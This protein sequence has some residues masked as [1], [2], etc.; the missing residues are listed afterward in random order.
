MT[1][2][3]DQELESSTSFDEQEADT[4]VESAPT[5]PDGV[6]AR[7]NLLAVVQD[8][9][10]PKDSDDAAAS[11]ADD[12][13]ATTEQ[14]TTAEDVDVPPTD[15]NNEFGDV[16]FNKHPRFQ[17]LVQQ[18]NEFRT[19]HEEYQKIQTFLQQNG[20]SAD[21]AAEMLEIGA[22]IERNP[23]EALER[24]RPT[25]QKLVQDAG[26]VLPQ[27]LQEDVRMGRI[28]KE[29]AKEISQLRAR[30]SNAQREQEFRRQQGER[31]QAQRLA[32]EMRNA[33]T[34]WEQQIRQRDPDAMSEPAKEE[35]MREI[36]YRHSMGQRP[37]DPAG[38]QAQLNEA[39]AAVQRRMRP[40]AAPKAPVQPVRGGR[41]AATQQGEPKSIMDIV[42]GYAT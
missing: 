35:L 12:D 33:A 16:P 4:Q 13:S 7:E 17:Q 20:L 29:R 24:L 11:Q 23:S 30:Q 9:V 5:E 10:R 38:V 19:G 8:A 39:W 6:D 18:R 22:L 27:D 41:A 31:E 32:G 25:L 26:A 37:K 21:K 3:N 34:A 2:E 36:A 42:Q 40:A 14:A 15:P 28:T 1:D